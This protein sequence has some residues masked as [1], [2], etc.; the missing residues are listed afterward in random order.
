MTIIFV[1]PDKTNQEKFEE[2]FRQ[3]NKVVC[4]NDMYD[5]YL[6]TKKHT[7]APDIIL[8]EVELNTPVG[9]QTLKFLESK[10]K[11]AFT[12]LIAFT[13][14]K[15]TEAQ[16]RFAISEGADAIFEKEKLFS[17]LSAYI[18][19]LNADRVASSKAPKK[20]SEKK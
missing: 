18:K 9:L 1:D 3:T 20:Y 7:K 11:L 2:T 17:E 4:F 8:I 14:E 15:F 5:A 10:S 6:W 12:N 16:K 19:F 13:T